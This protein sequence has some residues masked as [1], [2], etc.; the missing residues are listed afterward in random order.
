MNSEDKFLEKSNVSGRYPEAPACERCGGPTKYES[1]YDFANNL[2]G[3][4]GVMLHHDYR[5]A[6]CNSTTSVV[7]PELAATR[8]ATQN[9]IPATFIPFPLGKG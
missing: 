7:S 2:G 8:R 6:K 1:T 4:K 5:C 3:K 9:Q